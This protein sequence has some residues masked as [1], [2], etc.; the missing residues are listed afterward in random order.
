MKKN[1]FVIV[2]ALLVKSVAS[3]LPDNGNKAIGEF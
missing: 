2:L 1:L 3:Q